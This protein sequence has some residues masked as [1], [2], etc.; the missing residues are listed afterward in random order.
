MK[1][2]GRVTDTITNGSKD[3][4]YELI[5][6]KKY[7]EYTEYWHTNVLFSGKALMKNMSE[8]YLRYH[9]LTQRKFE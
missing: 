2:Q 8:I 4:E 1:E 5:R 7:R 9:R 6:N 3:K